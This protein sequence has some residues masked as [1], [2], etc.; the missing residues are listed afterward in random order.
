[1]H[2]MRNCNWVLLAFLLVAGCGG[3]LKESKPSAGTGTDLVRP[4]RSSEGVKQFPAK[5]VPPTAV[6]PSAK[7]TISFGELTEPRWSAP[8]A[9]SNR[10]VLAALDDDFSSV[11]KSAERWFVTQKNDFAECLIG[12]VS[13]KAGAGGG[14]LRL[15]CATR[16]TDDRT[17]KYLGIATRARVRLKPS[18]RLSFDFDWNDQANGCYLTGAM[19]LCPTLT[20]ENPEDQ[21]QWLKLEYVGVPPGKNARAAVWLKNGTN[22]LISLHD[23]GWPKEQ[24]TGRSIG[25]QHVEVDF[26]EGH[27]TIR[28]NGVVLCTAAETGILPF[29]EAYLYLQMSSHSNYPRRE[30]FFDQVH[31][32]ARGE[33]SEQP[34]NGP[35]F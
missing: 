22:R 13:D 16:G 21:A 35:A 28:E 2:S 12:V 26:K 3:G 23:E 32:E 18:A 34:G 24:R 1:M 27:W 17:V 4:E 19:I 25:L 5:A 8:P 7:S 9:E 6:T 11:T 31:F 29:D 14:R 10:P 15:G 33:W 20:T 30:L